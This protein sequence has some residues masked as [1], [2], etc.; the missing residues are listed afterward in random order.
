VFYGG[1]GRNPVMG[2]FDSGQ[3]ILHEIGHALGLKHG[4]ESSVYGAMNADRLDIEFSL[5][6]YPNYIGSTEGFGTAAQSPQTYMLYD[7]AALQYVYGANFSQAG[8]DNIYTWSETSGVESI[9]GVSQG[10]PFDNHIFETI[11]TGGA[12]STYDLSHFSQNQV[13]DMNPGGWMDFSTSQLADLNFYAPSKPNGEIFARGNIYN[14][15]EFNGDPRS[16]I[17]KIKTGSG[18]DV[19]IGNS[20]DNTIDGGLGTDTVV[21][22]GA[23]ADYLA[24][25]LGDGSIRVADERAGILD[26]TDTDFNVEFFRFS[27]RT[28]SLA[29]LLS[30]P[31]RPP[32]AVADSNGTAKNNTLSVCAAGGVLAN[33]SDPDVNDNGQLF[34]SQVNGSVANIGVAIGGT[35]G[36]LILNLDGSYTY[37]AYKGP[38]PAKIVAQDTFDY[39]VSDGHGGSD[40]STLSIVA[41]NRGVHYQSGINTTL[42][43]GNGPDV[44]DGSGGGD[45]L[46]GSN[47]RDVLIGG[48]GDTLVGGNGRD[49]FLFRPGFGANTITDFNVKKDSIQFNASLFI[50]ACAIFDHTTDTAAGAMITD[51]AGDTLTLTGVTAGNLAAHPGVF[52]L[53]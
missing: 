34:V 29:E 42:N 10:T 40:T 21:Y 7:I 47:G 45:I 32:T 46:L 5:M 44:L 52:Q 33:D 22:S 37:A 6:N 50:N 39:T 25:D 4:Q 20:A 26:G 51:A 38:L 3:S 9:N 27:D 14:A 41:F 15:L 53:A 18:D 2:N 28:Y 16:L 17:D 43:G 35:Y 12:N 11:W 30:Q 13:D 49:T 23:R 24:T 1:T 8:Q 19:I 31:N 48:D 36:S